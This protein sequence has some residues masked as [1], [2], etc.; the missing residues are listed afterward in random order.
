MSAQAWV[1]M[2]APTPACSSLARLLDWVVEDALPTYPKHIVINVH[3]HDPA[4]R[5]GASLC[6]VARHHT[7]ALR[8]KLCSHL[9]C[10]S[11][12]RLQRARRVQG[13]QDNHGEHIGRAGC[14]SVHAV[15]MGSRYRRRAQ[16]HPPR[17][18]AR[19]P[20][21]HQLG[22]WGGDRVHPRRTRTM[23]DVF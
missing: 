11:G 7:R 14:A 16:S 2:L 5:R 8:R 4:R 12:L 9:P 1:K 21:P 20:P 13:W 19:V 23:A 3:D 22:H 6:C 10:A 17:R 18:P 15:Q